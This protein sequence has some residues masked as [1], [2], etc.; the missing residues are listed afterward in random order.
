MAC[1]PEDYLTPGVQ[2]RQLTRHCSRE[3]EMARYTVLLYEDAGVHAALVP[4]LDVAT[5]GATVEEA[6][7][8]AQEAATL[9]VR[10]LIEDGEPVLIEHSPPIVAEIEVV[11]PAEVTA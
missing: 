8:M 1:G 2:P 11:V 9:Q 4:V 6:L 10:G 3:P 7:A 5:Q